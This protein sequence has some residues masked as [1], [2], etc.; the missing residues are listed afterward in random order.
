MEIDQ[1]KDKIEAV[2]LYLF[3]NQEHLQLL[4]DPYKQ[5]KFNLMDSEDP[6]FYESIEKEFE[7]LA[8]KLI[9]DDIAKNIAIDPETI[10]LVI[11]H[12]RKILTVND[13]NKQTR[14]P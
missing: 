7:S 13:H 12:I 4:I 2:A 11:E 5:Q 1:Q 8:R 3:H 10:K 6:I 9:T 14:Q